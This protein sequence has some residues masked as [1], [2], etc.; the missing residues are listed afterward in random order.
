MISQIEKLCLEKNI[1][2]T[3]NR[4]IIAKVISKSSDHPDVEEVY[5][6][7]QKINNNIGIATV[8]RTVKM[9][10]EAGVITKHDFLNKGRARYEALENEDHHDHIVDITNDVVIEFFNEEIEKL[11]EKIAEQHGFELVGH[12]LELYCRPIVKLK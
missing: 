5:R 1:K 9:F 2:L 4:K 7:A 12:K 10:E 6:R 8:Y 11:K 3:E